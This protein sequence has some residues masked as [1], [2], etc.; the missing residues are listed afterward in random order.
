MTADAPTALAA[1]GAPVWGIFQSGAPVL[2]VDSVVGFNF[3]RDWHIADYPMEEGAFGSYNKVN[4]P[5][6]ARVEVTKGGT[7][8]ER[9]QFLTQVEAIS[10]TL[11]LYDVNT[12]EFIYPNVNVQHYDMRRTSISGVQL[13]TVDIWLREIRQDVIVEFNNT[14]LPSGNNPINGGMVQP[15][16]PGTGQ[17]P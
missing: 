1:F 11:D 7:I 6:D 13:L 2:V 8:G 9:K 16:P 10:N 3:R 14:K 5:Y 4:I 15:I 12:P 17:S